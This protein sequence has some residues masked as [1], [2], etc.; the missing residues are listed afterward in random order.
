MSGERVE[1][2][3]PMGC[4]PART[5]FLDAAGRVTCGALG[6]PN[7]TVV[8]DLL[9]EGSIDAHVVHLFDDHFSMRH[10]LRE[11]GGVLFDCP[12]HRFISGWSAPMFPPGR[13]VVSGDGATAKWEPMAA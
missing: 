13:Y 12:L 6:C 2:R 11:R 5:L 1:G 3:C 4:G 8:D 10:P 7:P 9:H